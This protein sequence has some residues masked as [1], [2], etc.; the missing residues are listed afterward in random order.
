MS[1]RIDF[2]FTQGKELSFTVAGG[3]SDSL[4]LQFQAAKE[5]M[6]IAKKSLS[7]YKYKGRKVFKFWFAKSDERCVVVEDIQYDA[8]CK[9]LT[10]IKNVLENIEKR[11]DISPED[12]KK[13]L[14]TSP[15]IE[16]KKSYDSDDEK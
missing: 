16:C 10:H 12:V 15:H 7:H 11:K 5:I 13:A 3:G 8:G 4:Q 6:N 1:L 2:D 9:L 14:K